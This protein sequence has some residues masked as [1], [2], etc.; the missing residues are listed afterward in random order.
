MMDNNYQYQWLSTPPSSRDIAIIDSRDIDIF[1]ELLANQKQSIM[2]TAQAIIKKID[3]DSDRR[4][5]E[6]KRD[7]LERWLQVDL[8]IAL[9]EAKN[10]EWLCLSKVD[11][12]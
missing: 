5:T 8:Q 11:V 10:Y 6:L 1:E 4:Q 7:M 2:E 9:E 12:V 3:E